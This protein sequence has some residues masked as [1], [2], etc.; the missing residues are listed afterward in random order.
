MA[1]IGLLVVSCASGTD[2]DASTSSVTT[3]SVSPTSSTQPAHTTTT[4]P[5]APLVDISDLP[6]GSCEIGAVPDGG[7]PTVLVGDRLYGLGADLETPRCLL[8]GVMSSDIEWGPLA[9]RLRVGT[10][11][12]GT[13]RE[14]QSFGDGVELEWTAP[15]GTK[16][17]VIAGNAL[18]KVALDGGGEENIKFL[19][20]TNAVAYHPAGTHLLAVGTDAFGQY[21]LWFASNDGVNYVL[22]AF[23][24]DAEIFDPTWSWLN[25]PLFV[26]GHGDGHWHIHR[27]ELVDGNFEGPIVFESTDPI[28]LLMA[29]PYDPVMLG[30]RLNGEQ[31]ESCVE[32]STAAVTGV[33][34]PSPLDRF[35]SAPIGWLS[36]ERLLILA[37][38]DGCDSHAELWSFSAGFCPGSIYGAE[39][40]ISGVDGAAAREAVPMAPPSPDF[41]GIIEPAPA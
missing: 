3:D 38:P 24:E 28:D 31:G 25:E 15:T 14:A 26:A 40:L 16:V 33:D 21:G 12:Y 37:Y 10:D 5:V 29:S 11:V 23:D 27:V 19:D 34:L 30:Y 7:E 1:V 32:G 35:T 17:V 6:Q 36:A 13:G 8:E 41:T 2:G 39:L 22:M 9:D 18:T 4:T 20:M